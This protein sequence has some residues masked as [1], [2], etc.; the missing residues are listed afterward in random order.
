MKINKA[1]SAAFAAALIDSPK[2]SERLRA[3]ARAWAAVKEHMQRRDPKGYQA[4]LDA[5]KELDNALESS[6][7][8]R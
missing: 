6:E 7:S 8:K 5:V 2:P 3:V 1:D 4:F